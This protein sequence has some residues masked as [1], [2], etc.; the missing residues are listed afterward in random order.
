M[1]EKL[2]SETGSYLIPIVCWLY[3]QAK[4]MT[5]FFTQIWALI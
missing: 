5:L 2:V 1:K 3:L 4:S